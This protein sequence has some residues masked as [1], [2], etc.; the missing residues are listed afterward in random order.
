MATGTMIEGEL[1]LRGPLTLRHAAGIRDR[2][3]AAL[4]DSPRLALVLEDEGTVDVSFV[5]IL[6]AAQLSA[7]LAGGA[8]RLRH[9]PGDALARVLEEGGFTAVAGPWREA[10]PT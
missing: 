9:A 8:L 7:R 10:A 6:L 3:L 2:L 5:Q 4:Q 1:T